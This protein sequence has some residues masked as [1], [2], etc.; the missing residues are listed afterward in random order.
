MVNVNH[1]LTTFWVVKKQL[2]ALYNRPLHLKL[3]HFS[4]QNIF[5]PNS[6]HCVVLIFCGGFFGGEEREVAGM[7]WLCRRGR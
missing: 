3:L 7:R 1:Y 5:V 4:V 2:R 6:L